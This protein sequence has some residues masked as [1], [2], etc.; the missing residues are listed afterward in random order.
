M[1]W[2]ISSDYVSEMGGSRLV[3]W[4]GK[5][6]ESTEFSDKSTHKVRY[7]VYQAFS[8]SWSSD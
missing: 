7:R 8:V 5:T 1:S 4:A 2:S 3:Q 6:K